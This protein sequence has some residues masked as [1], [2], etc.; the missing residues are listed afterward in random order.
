M[1]VVSKGLQ[2]QGI[3]Y[4]CKPIKLMPVQAAVDL[5]QSA[6]RVV[7]GLI[8]LAQ[9]PHIILRRDAAAS[10]AGVFDNAGVFEDAFVLIGGRR[11]VVRCPQPL[12]FDTAAAVCDRLKA[13]WDKE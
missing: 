6:W 7:P 12:P 3:V 4:A 2:T 5:A 8:R 10:K 9:G 13:L 1:G 11:A